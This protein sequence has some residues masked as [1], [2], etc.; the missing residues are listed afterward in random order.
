MAAVMIERELLE[1]SGLGHDLLSEWG[2]WHKD[3]GEGWASWSVKPRIDPGY[4]GTP[5]N[6]VLL[7]ERI[8]APIKLREPRRY[9]IIEHRYRRD[10]PVW[11]LARE[12]G[13]TEADVSNTLWHACGIVEREFGDA[14]GG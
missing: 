9:K 4:H 13:A 8:L 3:D 11:L 10:Y 1:P 12:V 5:P 2:A 14:T 6:R 7:V